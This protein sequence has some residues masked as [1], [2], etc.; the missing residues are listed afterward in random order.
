MI[1]G[2]IGEMF[3]NIDNISNENINFGD[4]ILP[5]ISFNGITIS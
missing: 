5:W 4:R 1:S 2:N 3:L